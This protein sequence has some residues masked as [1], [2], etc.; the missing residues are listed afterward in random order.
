MM[1][2]D[3]DGEKPFSCNVCMLSFVKQFQLSQHMRISHADKK[4]FGCDIC[5]KL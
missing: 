4:N 2:H 5:G 1:E 3:S